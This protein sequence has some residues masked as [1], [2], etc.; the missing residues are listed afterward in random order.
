MAFISKF[1]EKARASW[2][3]DISDEIDKILTNIGKYK[4]KKAEDKN[5]K[6]KQVDQ[7]GNPVAKKKGVGYGNETGQI[8]N[9]QEYIES[10][11]TKNQ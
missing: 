5:K 9:V 11:E 1:Q 10:K 2:E 7:F 3:G 4:D 8:W 6:G